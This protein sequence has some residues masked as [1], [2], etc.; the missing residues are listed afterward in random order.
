MFYC[1][2]CADINVWPKS[3]TSSTGVC[4]VCGECDDCNDIKST[5]LPER[6]KRQL[7]NP[8]TQKPEL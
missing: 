1:D 5:L 4:E 3:L 8:V 7:I 6:K 2:K